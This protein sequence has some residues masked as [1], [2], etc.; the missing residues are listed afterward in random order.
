MRIRAPS[1]C[2]SSPSGPEV[3]LWLGRPTD[4][5]WVGAQLQLVPPGLSGEPEQQWISQCFRC[6]WALGLFF[7]FIAT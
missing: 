6:A 3:Q 1:A 5:D 4:A 2:Q 7:C